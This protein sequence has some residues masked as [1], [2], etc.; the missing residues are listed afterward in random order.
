MSKKR[1]KSEI[2]FEIAFYE[3]ILGFHEDYADVLAVIGHLYTERGLFEKG[4]A[5]DLKLARLHPESALVQY[6]LACSYA[7]TVQIDLAFEALDRAFELGYRDWQHMEEDRDLNGI[8][9]DPRYM[10]LLQR[11]QQGGDEG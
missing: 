2:D 10:P 7:L 5:V 6:N 8:R 9:E 1:K 3:G 11:M 4:L